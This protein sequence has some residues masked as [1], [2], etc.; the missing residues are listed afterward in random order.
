[1]VPRPHHRHMPMRLT[2]LGGDDEI[3]LVGQSLC[4]VP[5]FHDKPFLRPVH[6]I[7][8]LIGQEA[9]ELSKS[10]GVSDVVDGLVAV[11]L[12]V[13]RLPVRVVEGFTASVYEFEEVR[14]FPASWPHTRGRTAKNLELASC[15]QA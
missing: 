11:C 12:A 4:L 6:D 15:H 9:L 1:M 14:H 2:L 7:E 8:H 13:P 5:T 3:A 10:K